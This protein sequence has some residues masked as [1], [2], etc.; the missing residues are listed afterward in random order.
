M[1]DMPDICAAAKPVEASSND[2]VS[3]ALVIFM[4]FAFSN[5]A[6]VMENLPGVERLKAG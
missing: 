5:H 4:V 1:L 2:V 3:K 6:A